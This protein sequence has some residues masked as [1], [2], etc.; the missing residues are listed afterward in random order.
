MTRVLIVDDHPLVAESIATALGASG[1]V[2]GRA[3]PNGADPREALAEG[4]FDFCLVDLDWG[5]DAFSGVSFIE[6][7]ND[8]GATCIIL[9]GTVHEPLFGYCLEL[10]AAGV[11]TKQQSFRELVASIEVTIA[12]ESPN[13]DA[14]KYRWLLEAHKARD[15]HRRTLEPFM[16]LTS[17]EAGVLSDLR[18]GLAVAD[19]ADQRCVAVSTVRTHVRQILQK[20]QVN[21]Q[22]AAVAMARTAGW[23]EHQ[24][25]VD[26]A[27]APALS[28]VLPMSPTA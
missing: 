14:D 4:S 8:A 15:A 21:S 16:A 22:L 20:R 27:S 17:A 28:S 6:A 12:G 23:R 13:S 7:V 11:I 2:A 1:I 18:A 5:H 10:G 24:P 9:T 19:I 3:D 26:T 25:C